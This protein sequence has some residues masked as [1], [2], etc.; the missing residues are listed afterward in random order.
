[1]LLQLTPARLHLPRAGRPRVSNARC[2]CSWRSSASKAPGDRGG[3]SRASS[4]GLTL[5]LLVKGVFVGAGRPGGRPVDSAQSDATARHRCGATIVACVAGAAITAGIAVLYDIAYVRAT[6][7]TVLGGVLAAAARA[8]SRSRRRSTTRP[9][10]PRTSR[11][12]PHA[13]AVVPGA[14][15]S[16]RSS[17][18]RGTCCA[19]GRPTSSHRRG[20]RLSPTSKRGLIF[21]LGF[22][23]L[24]I[25]LLSPSSRFAER[26]AFS[27]AYMIGAAGVVVALADVV[28]AQSSR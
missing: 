9:R 20:A 8:R 12:L 5:G 1:M 27:A 3:G 18:A 22:A 19:I 25:L 21:A 28:G 6:G 2:V 11:V 26:Y 23:A 14:V 10:W 24:A 17:P 13:A 4:F 16:A 7:E 15:E